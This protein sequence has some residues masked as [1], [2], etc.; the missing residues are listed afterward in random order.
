MAQR[1]APSIMLAPYLPLR[2]AVSIA[3]WDLVPY[4]DIAGVGAGADADADGLDGQT[5]TRRLMRAYSMSGIDG[6]VLRRRGELVVAPT[7]ADFDRLR[8]AITFATLD[9]NPP[10][11]GERCTTE[12]ASLYAHRIGPGNFTAVQEGV[13]APMIRG[14]SFGERAKIAPPAALPLPSRVE[15]D[16]R[17][18][19]AIYRELRP[20]GP[21]RPQ[22]RRAIEWLST[23]WL[24]TNAVSLDVRVLA[25]RSGIEALMAA[26]EGYIAIAHALSALVDSPTAKRAPRRWTTLAGKQSATHELTERGWWFVNLSFLRNDRTHGAAAHRPKWTWRGEHQVFRAERELRMAIR[27]MLVRHGHDATLRLPHDERA[28]R[29]RHRQMAEIIA[30]HFDR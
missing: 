19:A 22:L 2:R 28:E 16:D 24:N 1:L 14:I 4:R 17:L 6:A 8:W 15:L 5:F 30:R 21:I 20:G 13:M 11:K 9:A 25:F 10:R 23:G 18:A 29:R 27:A 26:G 3:T 12:N 7:R